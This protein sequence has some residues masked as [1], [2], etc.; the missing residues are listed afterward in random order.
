MKAKFKFNFLEGEMEIEENIQIVWLPVFKIMPIKID[1]KT[2]F[3][4]KQMVLFVKNEEDSIFYATQ[5][6]KI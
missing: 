5:V 4:T 3:D 6:D 1:N 2:E